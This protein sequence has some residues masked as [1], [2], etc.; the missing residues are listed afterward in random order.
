[1]DF[2][3]LLS[4]LLMRKI[5]PSDIEW[6]RFDL[7]KIQWAKMPKLRIGD[8]VARLKPEFL[9]LLEQYSLFNRLYAEEI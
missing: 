9:Q 2:G 8:S 3:M 5:Y 7:S 4:K 1:M 6:P